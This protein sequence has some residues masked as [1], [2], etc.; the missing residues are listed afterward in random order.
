LLSLALAGSLA[1]ALSAASALTSPVTPGITHPEAAPVKLGFV[2]VWPEWRDSDSFNSITEYLR[3][4]EVTWGW[5]IRRTHPDLRGGYYFIGRFKNKGPELRGT[6][7][8]LRI[9]NSDSLEPRTYTFNANV[10]RGEPVF[11]LGLTGPDW[12]G[13]GQHPV[14]WKLELQDAAGQVLAS[15]ASFLWEKPDR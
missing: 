14:A 5:I 6:V 12:T 11:E 7:F 10:P 3:S 15:K 1:P 8:V 2:R 13:P 4:R 9:L